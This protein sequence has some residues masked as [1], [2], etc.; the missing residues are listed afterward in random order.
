VIVPGTNTTFSELLLKRDSA[1][2][3]ADYDFGS[4]FP[5]Q[6]NAIHL[7]APELTAG[8]TYFVRVKTPVTSQT[9]AFTM[10][11][12]T[13]LSDM[14]SLARP[15][16]KVLASQAIGR[17]SANGRQHFRFDLRTSSALQITLN[18]SNAS[19]DLFLQRGQIP[20]ETVFLKRSITLSNDL[21]AMLDTEA[22]AGAYYVGVF[23]PA[24][25]SGNVPFTLRIDP[26]N[27]PAMSWDPGTTHEG[28]LVQSNFTGAAGD[29]YFRITTAN[30]SLGAWRT[31]LRVLNGDANLYLSRGALPTP[32][33]ADFRSERSGSDGF[34]LNS[35]Q[36]APNESW[37]I[38]VRASAG[39]RWTLVSGAPYVQDLGLVANDNSSGSGSVEIGPEGMRFF[40]TTAPANMLAW[41][42]W[43]NGATNGIYLKRTSL[44]FPTAGNNELTANGALLVVPPYLAGNQQYLIGIVGDP[45]TTNTLDS[46]QQPIVDV[47]YGANTS[48]NITGFP[49]TTFRVQV[50]A[51][52]IAWQLNL[53]A[54]TNGNPNFA[55]RRNTVPNENN[56]DAL[57]ELTGAITDNI[58]LV[59][60]VLSDGT[61]YVTVWGTGPHQFTLQ[62]GPATVTDIN[63]IGAV[64]NNDTNRPGWRFY[65]VTD[66]AQQLGSLGWELV[67]ANFAPGTRIALRRNAA[68]SIWI[69]RNPGQGTSTFYDL[70]STVEVL[71]QPGH[72]ADI[73]Y[74]GVYQPTNVLGA[75]T[76]ITRE[77][78]AQP[79]ANETPIVRTDRPAGLWE[80]FRLDVPTN[81]NGSTVLGWDLRVTN[82]TRGYPVVV[83]R[84]DS[85]PSSVGTTINAA[86]STWPAGASWAANSDWTLRPLPNVGTTNENGRIL[87]MGMGRPLEPGVYYI[88]VMNQPAYPEPISYALVS[89]WIGPGLSIPVSPLA[90]SGGSVSNTVQPREADYYQI[91]IPPNKRSW[92]VR[93]TPV[94]GEAMLV[95]ATNKLMNVLSEKRVQKLGKEQYVMLPPSG[96]EFLVPGT[97]YMAVVGEGA[98]P[99]D[100]T[101]IGTDSSSYVLE[102]L[103]EMSEVELGTLTTTDLIIAGS[104]EG[105][106]STAYHFNTL[107]ET[108]GFWIT[109]EDRVGNPVAVSHAGRNLAD[110]GFV[111]DLYGNE[112][113]EF[114]GAISSS[115]LIVVADPGPM[116]T[117]MVKA[118]VNA[119]G[120]LDASYTLRVQE[121][122]P[123]PLA[124]NGGVV[125]EADGDGLKGVFYVIDVPAGASGWDIRLTNV[126][127]GAPQLVVARDVLPIFA[128]TVGFAPQLSSTW[129]PGARWAAGRDWTERSLSSTL[130][131]EDG[132]ILAMGMGR[133]LEPGR[134]YA[135]VL[136]A[137]GAPMS[138]T[139]VSRG[140]GSGL[141][142]PVTDVAFDGGSVTAGGLPPREAAYFRVDVPTNVPSWKVRVSTNS[143]EVML[144]AYKGALPNVL[145]NINASV[146]N[147]AGRKMQKV[148]DEYF[149]LLPP[150]GLTNLSG[151]TYYLAVIGEGVSP[152]AGRVGEGT[153][154]FTLTSLGAAP[155]RDL[156]QIGSTEVAEANT[157]AAGDT[158]IYRFSVPAGTLA[159][160]AR[161]TERI[162]NPVMVLRQG[163]RVADPGT[164]AGT[165]PAEFYGHDNGE[166]GTLDVSPSFLNIANPTNG[167]Y[168][169]VVMARSTAGIYS[170][171]SYT[172]RLNASGSFSAGFDNDPR[173]VTNHAAQTWRYF[174]VTVPTNA[175][176][177]D[178]RLLNVL[179]GTPRLVIRRETLPNLVQ[180]TPWGAPGAATAWPTNYQWAPGQDWTRRSASAL[181]A[182][183]IEDGRVFACGM[184][185][186][187]EPGLYFIGVFNTHVTAPASYTFLSRGI[188]PGF[189][190][191]LIDVPFVGS[192]TNTSLPGR[193]AAYFRVY[194]PSNAPSWKV[195][196]RGTVGESMMVALRGG[197]PNIDMNTVLGQ[198]AT[199]KGMQKLGNDHYLLLPTTGTTNLT[200]STNYFAVISEGVNPPNA[201]RMGAGNSSIIFESQGTIRTN[202]LG[203]LTSEDILY[204]DA[205]EGG[206]VKLYQFVVPSGML[207]LRVRLENRVGNPT[208]VLRQ[209]DKIPDPGVGLPAADVYGTEGGYT[210]SDG[211][212]ALFTLPNPTPGLY[213]LVVKARAAGASYPDAS[214]T[215]RLQ[216]VLVPELNFSAQ[217]NTNGIS[218]TV[219]GVLEDNERVF[220]KF[221]IP[222]TNNGQA[223]VGWKLDLIQSQGLASMRARRDILPADVNAAS[224]MPFTGAS[225]IIVPPFLTN[226]VWYVEVRGSG[227]TAFTLTS[228]PLTLE[229][230]A[231]AMP[232]PG[233]ANQAPGVTLPLFGDSGVDTNGAPLS[234][235]QSTFLQQGFLHYY[236]VSVPNTNYGLLRAAL[237]AL[238]GNPDL[239]LRFGAPPTLYHS[240]AGAAGTIFDR[241]MLANATEYANWVPLDGKLET[242]LKPGL[243]YMAVR[244]A[245]NANA[246]YRLKLSVGNITEVPV[247]GPELTNQLVAAGDWRYYR[248]V[249]PATIPG[250]F[251]LTFSQQVG[252][253]IVH[254]RDTIPP[255]NGITGAAADVRDW[256]FD[257]KNQ[258]PYPNYDAPNT[259]PF[260]APPVRPGQIYYFG[261]RALVDSTFSIRVTT[262]GAPYVELPTIPFYGG[263]VA[264]TNLQPSAQVLYRIDVPA[265]ATRWKHVGAHA[266]GVMLFLDQGTLP[267]KQATDDWR[268]TGASNL[269]NQYLLGAWPWVPNQSYF[270]LISN[271]TAQAQDVTF[272]MDGRNALTDDNDNDGLPDAW[273]LLY[274]GNTTTQSALG[275]PDRDLVTNAEEYQ[276]NTN[277]NDATSYRP[278][279]FTPALNGTISRS[280][281]ATSYALGAQVALSPVAAPGF[282]FIGW[283]GDASGRADPF[284]ITMTGHK[285]VG[286]TFHLAGDDFL[287]ALPLIGTSATALASNVSM[288]KEFGEPN[289]AGNPGGKSIWWRWTA[290]TSGAVTLTT[291]GSAFNTLLAV[292]TGSTVSNLT[293]IASDNNSGGTISRSTVHFTATAGTTYDIAVDGVNGASSRVNLNLTLGV[294][295][296]PGTRPELEFVAILPDAPARI[297]VDGEPNHTYTI[298]ASTDLTTWTVVGSATTDATGMGTFVDTAAANLTQRFYRTRE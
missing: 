258:P 128:N 19:P 36:F 65:R 9:H 194:V 150:A 275:D 156:G 213:T 190:I 241:S 234:G 126:T 122:V 62:N 69:S 163:S 127:A 21:I 48:S 77:L 173:D 24:V 180:T 252:D 193:E 97:A 39:A 133:P 112:G 5:G 240:V 226:G 183:I 202:D 54:A 279:L 197:L 90:W 292:Y 79:L 164:G 64:T 199:G 232:A 140:I 20:N 187:L 96:Q 88:G 35:A 51:Q 141:N 99:P 53:P 225:A 139:L 212:T 273:E 263:V 31:A 148:G 38:L 155:V 29:F 201:A 107:P 154:A 125:N 179:A 56:N 217:M 4:S 57:S 135:A 47:A 191:P 17:I 288:T 170:N 49:Y 186:P 271:S 276:E 152:A 205:L 100:N 151:G 296:G 287:T 237:E 16:S 175:L 260:T 136:G 278:R 55:L 215:I 253:V 46:R 195:K 224:L 81:V 28:T 249:A 176:G 255:G 210:S 89:R 181:D 87:A 73:W 75:F 200:A 265:D 174:R 281:D 66:I 91:T 239:Y 218:H 146:T 134:Y 86:G 256:L 106:E 115:S 291:A 44:P 108:L 18:A 185:R 250:G 61:F 204:P 262:N 143:G 50:P 221:N 272:A 233:E 103:G 198:L 30:P 268:S 259:Y 26:L 298:E 147:S 78:Q 132:R 216:E 13:N 274:F 11:V 82:V 1:P 22:T 8:G 118:R 105:G 70:L 206:E 227:S 229:R 231:W 188:G 168:T 138:Y 171:A 153:S 72:Q 172:L 177:W 165:T 3:D 101:R 192:A 203:L 93:L 129:P 12:Q 219:S 235:D 196:L 247:H 117:I 102:T 52:Q 261:V 83:V 27:V 32:A 214:Y 37:Y 157:L 109:L 207:G 80:F 63:Y 251:N 114:L 166:I 228:S 236:A 243:W 15:V 123:Q 59:P 149:L 208:F 223:V 282:S 34:V 245:G 92:K 131:S 242:K 182:T 40:S 162:G 158:Q 145:A 238:S 2:T 289:H 98:N 269:L 121:I 95:I 280:P 124:F 277:P 76:L 294:G 137:N 7:E 297:V 211:G 285:T 295:S 43:L 270:L 142:I 67:L 74:I 264:I 116:E 161:L 130:T 6:T 85:L 284:I 167:V 290:P 25:A 68:P 169:L 84:R 184:G 113:G 94:S 33:L 71:Q 110:P 230:P 222:A 10:L 120:F 189:A 144:V 266:A 178:L 104:L 220:F 14:R 209:G 257:N 160:E 45:G 254:V 159:L 248:F 60:P 244:A 286:A 58:T 119:S 111:G 42:L 293:W 41:R 246:R 23:A 267:T 283:T